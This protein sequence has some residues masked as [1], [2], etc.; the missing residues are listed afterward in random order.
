MVGPVF[1]GQRRKEQGYKEKAEELGISLD[2]LIDGLTEIKV[3]TFTGIQ[4]LI[5]LIRDIV[6]NVAQLGY[7][8]FKLERLIPLPKIGKIVHKFHMDKIL[9][10]LLDISFNT[11]KAEF[12]SI[13]LVDEQTGELYIK[14]AKGLTK[15][16]IKNAR[17][18]PGEGIAGLA[19]KERRFLLLDDSLTDERI[20]SRLKR[21]EIQSAVVAPLRVMDEPLGVMNI[22]TSN[23]SDKISPEKV[24]T[25]HRLIELTESTLTDLIKL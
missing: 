20:K 21:P 25:I 17:L 2:K 1:L 13:M 10:A 4:S 12:G 14:I 19:V 3:F 23:P 24:E 11:T 9:S 16:I 8:R 22:A 18:K 15:D 6:S 7:S 5:E